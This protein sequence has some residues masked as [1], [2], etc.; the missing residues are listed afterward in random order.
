MLTLD[1]FITI[2]Q[3]A[4]NDFIEGD[5]LRVGI[6]KRGILS[7]QAVNRMPD[8]NSVQGTEFTKILFIEDFEKK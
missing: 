1:R 4:K 5:D 8:K 6:T 3:E 7:I 2:L